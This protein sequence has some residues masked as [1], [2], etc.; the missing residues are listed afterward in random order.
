MF[1]EKLG[2][3]NIRI[4]RVHRVKRTKGDKSKKPGAIIC[5]LLSF[6]EKRLV[7]KNANKFKGTKIL[8]GKD[9]SLKTMKYREKVMGQG[10]VPLQ[11]R[12]R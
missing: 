7:M 11:S 10:K 9:Y 3:K 1:S 4:E 8:I 6:K 12:S 5:N 2:L